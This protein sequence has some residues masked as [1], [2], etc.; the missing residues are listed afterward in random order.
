MPTKNLTV[1]FIDSIDPPSS[2]RVE[3]WDEGRRA[4][5]CG[6]PSTGRKTWVVLYRHRGKVRRL[7]LGTYPTL[8]LADAREQAKDALRAAAKGKDP[9]GGKEGGTARRHVQGDGRG[10]Y[11]AARQAEQAV[12][13]AGPP[14]ARPGLAAGARQS[15][16]R[17]E[18]RRRDVI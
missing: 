18:V 16:A 11:R 17:P 2:G 14:G 10:L 15:E 1:R 7:T 9:A 13:E 12:M 4:S 3:Y 5:V 6:F 8:P